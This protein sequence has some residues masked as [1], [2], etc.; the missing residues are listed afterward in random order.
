M[1]QEVK[2]CFLIEYSSKNYFFSGPAFILRY[3][4]ALKSSFL[5]PISLN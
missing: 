1:D 5:C 2:F 4:S 3:S